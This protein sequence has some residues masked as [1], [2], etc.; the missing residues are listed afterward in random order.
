MSL[1][2]D[3]GPGSTVARV[4]GSRAPVWDEGPV[5]MLRLRGE[6]SWVWPAPEPGPGRT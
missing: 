6:F 2:P 1:A 4:A 3:T 5:V